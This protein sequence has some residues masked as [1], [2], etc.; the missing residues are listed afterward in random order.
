MLEEYNEIAHGSPQL[1]IGKNGITPGLIEHLG[2]LFKKQKIVKIKVMPETANYIG[3]EKIITELIHHLPLYVYDV[4]GFTVII[5]KRKLPQLKAKKKYLAIRKAII[6]PNPK[7]STTYDD[8]PFIDY[9]DEEQLKE[10]DEL[11]DE[12]YGAAPA[13]PNKPSDTK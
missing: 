3:M 6:S 13:T 1:H 9:D 8:A 11:S 2:Q 12:I 4:R 7:S 10:I 5:S